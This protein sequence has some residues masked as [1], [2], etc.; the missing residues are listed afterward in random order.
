MKPIE[1][2]FTVYAVSNLEKSRNFYEHILGFTPENVWIDEANGM[3]MV[4]YGLGPNNSHTLAIGSG[5]EQFKVG[6]TGGTFAVEVQDF[7]E[8]IKV[9]KDAQVNF[10]M[11]PHETSV[12]FMAMI[13]DID[14]N[15]LMIH[16]RK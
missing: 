5:A 16:K 10:V 8:A 14:G 7:D 6:Q 12:C 4:E 11:E 1:I 13:L 3:G 2:A 9:L 15:Q